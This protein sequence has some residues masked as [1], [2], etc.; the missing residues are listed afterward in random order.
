M[1]YTAYILFAVIYL[2]FVM[3]ITAL[4][5]AVTVLVLRLY[6]TRPHQRPPVWLRYV[7]YS[8]LA[9]LTCMT[10]PK[11]L[12]SSESED[13][14]SGDRNHADLQGIICQMQSGA[15]NADT[16]P[17]IGKSRR[18]K[19]KTRHGKST[20]HAASESC[21][22]SEYIFIAGA[23]DRFFAVSLLCVL[24]MGSIAMLCLVPLQWNRAIYQELNSVATD[25][26]S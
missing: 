26:P 9:K 2:L 18:T 23:I 16:T 7:V 14:P 24:V 11:E 20:A 22:R 3:F 10:V 6:H 21:V 13:T 25:T 8:I 19:D 4:T 17:S 12:Y 1:Q 15:I 5:L